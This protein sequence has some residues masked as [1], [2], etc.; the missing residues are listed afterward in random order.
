MRLGPVRIDIL[1][2]DEFRSGFDEG[3]LLRGVSAKRSVPASERAA[4]MRTARTGS[5]SSG[6]IA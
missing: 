4:S 5:P 6:A 1:G 3:G 2:G